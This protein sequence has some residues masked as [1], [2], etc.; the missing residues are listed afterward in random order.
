M[1]DVDLSHAPFS[2]LD[3]AGRERVRGGLDLA[4]FDC[5]EIIL[6]AGQPGENVFLIHKGE[7]AELDTTQPGE[8]QRIGH[9]T[10][11]DLFGAISILNG[12]SRYRFRAEQES[13]CYLLPRALFLELCDA[14]P[15]FDAFFRQRLADKARLLTEQ[16]AAGGVT[17][18]GFMLARAQDCMRPPRCLGGETT[19][20]EAVRLLHD[21]AVDSLL[22]QGEAGPGM[23]TKTD[24]LDALVL[25]GLGQE[26]PLSS[27]AGEELITARPDQYLFEVLV[28][29]TRRRIERVVIVEDEAPVGVV[30][31]T[32]VLSYFSSRSHVVSLQVEQA[33]DLK[34]LAS[35][36]RRTAEL[37]GALMAQ[38]VKLRFAMGLLAALN[39]RI[40]HKAWDFSMPESLRRD[41]CL[42]VMGS[43]GRG[44]QMLKTD[45]DN[46]L[47]LDDDLAW[48]DCMERMAEFTETLVSLGYP[49]CPGNIMVSNPD[50]VGT[51]RQ[52]KAR[53]A[54]WVEARDGD[55][56]MKL[57]I[58]LD[59]HAVAGNPALLE[60][61]RETLFEAASRDELLLSYFARPVMRFSTPLTLFGSLKKPQHGIDIKKGG[62]FPIVHGVRVMALERGILATGTLDRLD[63]LA[64]DGRL[65][66]RFAEDLGEALSLF[67]QLRLEQQLAR[68]EGD[69][70]DES[71]EP[72]R[73]VVQSL[74]SLERDLLREALHIVKDFKQRISHRYHLE[75]T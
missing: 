9:Y 33:G 39:G 5:D 20:A 15:A 53:I 4:Y 51:E 75:Y 35:A 70:G 38:G 64:A 50:W 17:M 24:L 37:A 48:P 57:A 10:G 40:I 7:V 55:S 32:D 25:E 13:L 46:G 63:A 66:E 19:I 8:R 45:Q 3:E 61:V 11:G 12:Q 27:L 69:G 1:V 73:V 68:L 23:V 67:T 22:V 31:L 60:R 56:L 52:W 18:A 16:R 34:Q 6:E 44:E 30:E 14:Y 47:I 62:I 74:S 59:A 21:E 43:E 54:R 26:T 49:R 65:E 58:M 42:M 28:L 36:S 41:S 2:L 72:D 29:M 71:G